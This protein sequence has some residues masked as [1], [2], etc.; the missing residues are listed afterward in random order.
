MKLT[1]AEL[2]EYNT[3]EMNFA[4]DLTACETML[5]APAEVPGQHAWLYHFLI[6]K[7]RTTGKAPTFPS[8]SSFGER[9]PDTCF[10]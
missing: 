7:P 5:V 10:A 1:D 9:A 8:T 2:I 3:D 4:S 6:V